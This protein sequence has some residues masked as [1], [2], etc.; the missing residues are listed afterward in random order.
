MY[1]WV[2]ENGQVHFGDKV[3]PAAAKRE[4]KQLDDNGQVRRVRAREPTAEEAL[5][6]EAEAR[7]SKAQE[8]QRKTEAAHD[9]ALLA[10]YDDVRQLELAR[11]EQLST[12]DLRLNMTDKALTER[13]DALTLIRSEFAKLKTL[14]KVQ[15][16]QLSDA[17]RALEE[18]QKNSNTLKRKR[19]TVE[20]R[21]A[22]DI[23]RFRALK[24]PPG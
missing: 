12:I 6:A 19:S 13:I 17:E 20:T 5:A 2:D 8:Q 24:P 10:T 4:I 21:F 3:P 9:R 23:A 22:D 18:A 11:D 1:R 7:A 16:K 15:Q 14:N